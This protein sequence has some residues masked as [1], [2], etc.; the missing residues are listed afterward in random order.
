MSGA[1]TDFVTMMVVLLMIG[2][3]CALLALWADTTPMLDYLDEYDENE[4]EW[5][6]DA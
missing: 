1:G 4:R 3:P 5:R 2:I 6:N